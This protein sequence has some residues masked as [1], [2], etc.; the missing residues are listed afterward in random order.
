MAKDVEYTVVHGPEWQATADALRDVDDTLAERFK[1]ALEEAARATLAELRRAALDLP[2]RKLKHTGLRAR[3][4]GGVGMKTTVKGIRFTTEMP[5]GQEELPRG[6]DNGVRG[7][8]HPVYGNSNVWVNQRGGS[9]FK[10]TIADDRPRFERSFNDVLNEAVD[11]IA[12]A[13]HL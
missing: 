7:W 1:T 2:A 13:T 10:S 5:P 11:Q 12:A 3:I 9:W 8:R 6:E 4:A